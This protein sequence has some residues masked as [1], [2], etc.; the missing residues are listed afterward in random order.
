MG[1]DTSNERVQ[2]EILRRMS[3]SERLELAIDLTA[4]PRKLPADGGFIKN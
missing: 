2:L 1:I 3:S 4:T